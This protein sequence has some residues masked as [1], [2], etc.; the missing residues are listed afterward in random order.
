MLAIETSQRTGSVAL[1]SSEEPALEASFPCGSREHDSLL[2]S[3]DSLISQSHRSPGEIQVVAVSI[4]PG[5]FTGLRIATSTAKALSL[6]TGCRIIGVPSA[7]VVAEQWYQRSADEGPV[8][9]ASAAKGKDCWL[10]RLERTPSGLAECGPTGLHRVDALSDDVRSLCEGAM[11]LAD[12]FISES[13][14]KSLEPLIRGVQ[15]PAPTA[16]ACLL[17]GQQ[18]ATTGQFVSGHALSPLYPR[19]PEA[20]ALWRTRNA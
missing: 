19:E 5:S 20:V 4:G 12:D 17:V 14:I 7:W 15:V 18:L 1:M 11:F 6:A 3:I 16:L 9:V 10:T 13:F 8:L 2:P